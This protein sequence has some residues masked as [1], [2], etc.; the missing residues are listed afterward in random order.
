MEI[1]QS[2][3]WF[4]A[5]LGYCL[6]NSEFKNKKALAQA[7]GVSPSMISEIMTK[8]SYGPK[9]QTKI[10]GAFGY[11]LIDFISLGRRVLDGESVNLFDSS[12]I[13]EVQSDREKKRFKESSEDFRGIPLYESGKLAAG[14]NGLIFDP[15]EEPVS[16][17]FMKQQE[18]TGRRNHKLMGLKVG[19]MSM[20]PIIPP[21]SIVV[22]DMDDRELV[23]NKIYAVNYP[24]DGENIA[25]VKRVQKW[26]HGFVLMSCNS[27]YPPVLSELDWQDLCLGRAV[28]MWRNLEDM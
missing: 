20:T 26:K 27:K 8:K 19:G 2:T 4:R 25:A 1:P 22:I 16:A 12:L 21:G 10:A 24:T 5:A 3:H 9:T 11:D 18:L 6:Q 7:A 15:Y 13:V 17:L 28:W 23:K 14:D